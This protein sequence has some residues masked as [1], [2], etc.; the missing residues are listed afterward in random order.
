MEIA[1]GEVR[2]RRVL[3]AVSLA[4]AAILIFQ[5]SELW[6]A[7]YRL[8][9]GKI[10]LMERGAALVPGNAAAWDSLGR[11][12]QWDFANPDLSGA[13]ADYRKAVTADPRSAH[14]WMDLASAYEAAGDSA[15]ARDAFL[16][17]KAVYPL[18]AEVA[19]Y[20]GNFLLRQQEYSEAYTELR[21]AVRTD[22]TLL[23][24]AISRTWRSSE[25]VDELLNQMLP[26]EADAY[27]QAL[28]FF[29]SIHRADPGLVVWQRL[30]GLGQP[31]VLSRTFPFFEELIQEDRGED[32][33]RMWREAVLA[34]GMPYQES[35]D[36]SLIWNGDF[37]RDLANGGLEWRWVPFPGISIDFDTEPAPHGS[38]A[39][40]LD[41][42]GG[43]NISLGAPLQYVPVEPGRNYRFHAYMRTQEITT[44]SGMRFSVTDPN[45]PD[46]LN[47]L[48]ENFTGSRGWTAMDA[49]LTTGPQTHFLLVRLLRNPSRLF[50]N[51]LSGTV[52]IADVSLVPSSPETDGPSR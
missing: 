13:I 51:K 16:H 46:A 19:F 2:R 35:R 41:F 38:R 9:S 43:S 25:D 5:S 31:I 1:L 47:L 10:E 37:T 4:T 27:L 50:D 45:H 14:Y 42:N 21:R 6:F 32:A 28:D 18:S 34:A 49:D 26:P 23:P 33:R 17:A 22:R 7:S 8:A 12:R 11:L 39:V 30:L 15:R 40:R 52:W 36:H 20:Y 44:E 29:A 24:L 48:T 3:L